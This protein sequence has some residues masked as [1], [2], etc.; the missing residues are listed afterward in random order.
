MVKLMNQKRLGIFLSGAAALL[1][2][3]SG[4]ALAKE[5]VAKSSPQVSVPP[6][7]RPE[8]VG[9]PDPT[10][11]ASAQE[12][13]QTF[14]SVAAP[15]KCKK[16]DCEIKAHT[17]HLSRH[18]D[19]KGERRVNGEISVKCQRNKPELRVTAELWETRWWGWDRISEL[20]TPPP[21]HNKRG[22]SAYAN[23]DC[24]PGMTVRVTG[25]G[26]VSFPDGKKGWAGV[27]SE[28]V[29]FDSCKRR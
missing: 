10:Q 13:P 11:E 14:G 5:E 25:D 12:A 2:S 9:I 19:D 4:L 8:T 26:Y 7:E 16:C 23:A 28:H 3:A 24:N 17:P 27:E 29:K 18:A 21:M 20:A 1:V 15:S 22:V 6:R